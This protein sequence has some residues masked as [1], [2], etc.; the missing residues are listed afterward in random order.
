M[1]RRDDIVRLR[2]AS[3]DE[4]WVVVV[5][6]LVLSLLMAARWFRRRMRGKK[7]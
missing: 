1:I 3:V 4:R 2:A 6:V 7:R 5:V